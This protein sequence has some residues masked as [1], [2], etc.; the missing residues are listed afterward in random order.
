MLLACDR[1]SNC[2]RIL[3]RRIALVTLGKKTDKMLLTFAG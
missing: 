3:I 1:A 2:H